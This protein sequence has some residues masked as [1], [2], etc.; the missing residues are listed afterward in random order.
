MDKSKIKSSGAGEPEP[1]PTGKI[2]KREITTELRDS[3]LDYA[4]SVIVGRALPDVRDGMKPVHRRIL[5][6]M[7][8]SGLT[9]SAKL[10]KSA[11]V[12]GE[13]LGR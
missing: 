1:I 12:V 8:D 4:M 6:S 5:W 9:S 7:W 13:V 2:N 10:R 3:Y 11:N